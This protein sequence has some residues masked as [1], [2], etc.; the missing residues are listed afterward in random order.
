MKNEHLIMLLKSDLA[1]EY[2]SA[3]R[4]ITCAAKMTNSACSEVVE[5]LKRKANEEIE[6]AMI[7]AEEICLLGGNPS[8]RICE[9][10]TA[11]DNDGMLEQDLDCEKDAVCR[12]RTRIQQ[13]ESMNHI[14]LAGQLREILA[15]EQSHTA[16][17]MATLGK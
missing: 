12:Y 5:E 14:E 6:H 13:A 11:E 10:S 9:V 1:K 17:L 2:S 15:D 7:L 3:I 8:V 16:E 4:Y